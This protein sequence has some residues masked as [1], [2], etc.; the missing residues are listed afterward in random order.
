MLTRR[1][2]KWGALWQNVKI[3]WCQRASKHRRTQYLHSPASG[4]P[5]PPSPPSRRR[6]ETG[7]VACSTPV[8]TRLHVR[9]KAVKLQSQPN[10]FK[11]STSQTA[12]A[13]A[14]ILGALVPCCLDL[15]LAHQFGE[16]LCLPLLPG[17][18]FAM[19]VGIRERYKIQVSGA[20]TSESR[21]SC[22]YLLLDWVMSVS[23]QG[24]VC[25]DWTTVYCCY[26]LAVCQMIR[27]MKRRMKT[28]TYHVA[29]T[30]QCSWRH[31]SG[32]TRRL[33]RKVSWDVKPVLQH[34]ARGRTYSAVLFF[35][36]LW[37]A[38]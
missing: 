25:E 1:K 13:L 20:K 14:G 16:C 4:P 10:C 27:E 18:T 8:E 35:F 5:L 9:D 7:T 11:P 38:G 19:R 29:T 12:V 30:L 34:W 24:S 28:Q 22:C 17:S 2:R 21:G 15:S 6:G 33:L 36:L 31:S 26:P 3:T 32:R 23:Q 37:G